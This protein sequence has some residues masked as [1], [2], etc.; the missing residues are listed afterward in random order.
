MSAIQPE[1]FPFELAGRTW[2]LRW[3]LSAIDKIQ[4]HFDE[5]IGETILRL[6]DDRQ[7]PQTAA[8]LISVLI[9]DEIDR[10][11]LDVD[12]LSEKDIMWLIDSTTLGRATGALLRSYG[13]SMPEDDEEESLK[14]P[15]RSLSP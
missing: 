4:E 1:G 9:A 2:H 15:E 14:N 10:E 8:Y 11:S 7:L 6:T 5:S 3:T 12:K 13:I